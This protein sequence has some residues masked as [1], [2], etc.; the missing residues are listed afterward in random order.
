MSMLA[1]DSLLPTANHSTGQTGDVGVVDLTHTR[2]TAGEALISAW[3]HLL[4]SPH[5]NNTGPQ[6]AR[7]P[8]KPYTAPP[9]QLAAIFFWGGA[10][11]KDPNSPLTTIIQ[12]WTMFHHVWAL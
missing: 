11:L 1:A 7:S 6:K 2:Y 9:S 5:Q 4:S 12:A 3:Y 10:A 8:H